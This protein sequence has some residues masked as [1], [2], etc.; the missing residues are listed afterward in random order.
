MRVA[1]L[2]PLLRRWAPMALWLGLGAVL[3]RLIPAQ[4]PAGPEQRFGPGGWTLSQGM[5]LRSA[6][7]ERE[8]LGTLHWQGRGAGPHTA[9]RRLSVAAPGRFLEVKACIGGS[10]D[11]DRAPGLASGHEAARLPLLAG[12]ADPSSVRASD[13]TTGLASGFPSGLAPGLAEIMLASVYR[14]HLDFNRAYRLG[15]LGGAAA[16]QCLSAVLPRRRGDGPAVLQIQLL[17]DTEGDA[18]AQ[19]QV[20]DPAR[21]DA[22][23]AAVLQIQLLG[24]A[25]GNADAQGQV[26]DP[27]RGDAQGRAGDKINNKVQELV[28]AQLSV[29]PLQENPA[30]RWTRRAMLPVGIALLVIAMASYAKGRPTRCARAGLL[31]VAGIV[32]GC[33]VSVSLK[34]DIYAVLT[35]GRSLPARLPAAELLRL[36]FPI[37]GLPIFTGL[38]ALLFALASLLLGLTQRRAWQDLMLLGLA[39]EA[40]QYFVPGRGPGLQ[41]VLVDWI[42]VFCGLGLVVL[43]RHS[44]RVSLLL[45]E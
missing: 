36:P 33:C 12:G 38:H 42:G 32:F 13:R 14:G 10:P 41:D 25:E 8:P 28:L 16:G 4:L 31:V 9:S 43:L 6:P 39:T 26:Q 21:G 34:A 45:Q 18:D 3:L 7:P 1:T 5:R 24:D 23:A 17:G 20:Q 19:G 2:P 15:A 29:R 22:D 40:L 27:A 35:G 30:W 44:G 11:A 37:G